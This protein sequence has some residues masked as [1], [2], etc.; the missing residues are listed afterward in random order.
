MS[1]AR[2]VRTVLGCLIIGS[3]VLWCIMFPKSA[4]ILRPDT[5]LSVAIGVGLAVTGM[6]CLFITKRRAAVV[7][8]STLLL[9]S[10][11]SIQNVLSDA[12]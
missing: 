1:T 7:T 4:D 11:L 8:L 3:A 6:L 9:W 10:V 5:A 12:A 2:V